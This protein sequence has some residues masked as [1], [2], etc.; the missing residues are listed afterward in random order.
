MNYIDMHCDTLSTAMVHKATSITSVPKCMLDIERLKKAGVKAQ[1]FAAFLSSKDMPKWYGK[2]VMP[3]AEE[4]FNELEI[5][6]QNT[7][8]ENDCLKLATTYEEYETNAKNGDISAIFTIENADLVQG[9]M[10]R[11]KSYR[12]RGVSLMT[13]TWNDPS[14]FGYNHSENPELMSKGLTPFGKEAIE[15]MNDIGI[16]VDVSHLSD[17]GFYDV[18]KISKKPFVASHS[19]CRSLSKATR[20][21][22]D[23]MIKVLADKG[24]VMGLNFCPA[25]LHDDESDKVGRIEEM[26]RHLEHMIK[27]GGSDIAGIG[28]DF[29][30]IGGQLEIPGCEKMDLLFDALSARGMSTGQIEKIAYK[31]VERVLKET[32]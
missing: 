10:E 16:I 12:K 17:G 6:L 5:M 7:I 31:N 19:N 30:G 22:T 2:E 13:L 21:M 23:D 25:F 27:V 20:N 29:D 9:S 15:V 32:L 11:L 4:L 18:A 24:G 3:P 28:T 8:R 1:F 14:C 26:C